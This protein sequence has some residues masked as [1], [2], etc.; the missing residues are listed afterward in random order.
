MEARSGR[1]WITVASGRT[2][3]SGTWHGEYRFRS[4]TGSRRYAFRARVPKQ[5]GYPYEA[6]RSAVRRIRV[7][8]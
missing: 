6:G 2:S 5:P 8:G 3:P 4:T 1:R 7:T